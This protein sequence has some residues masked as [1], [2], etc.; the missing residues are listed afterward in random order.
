MPLFEKGK[1][2]RLLFSFQ[3]KRKP[4][5]F[6][7]LFFKTEQSLPV[8]QRGIENRRV[9]ECGRG[10]SSFYLVI[11]LQSK[12]AIIGPVLVSLYSQLSVDHCDAL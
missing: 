10:A 7:L 4:S 3:I 1:E 6:G 9:H 12:A 5:Y 11:D 2:R 8:G